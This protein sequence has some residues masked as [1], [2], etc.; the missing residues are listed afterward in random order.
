MYFSQPNQTNYVLKKY[1]YDI[2]VTFASNSFA[3]D[4]ITFNTE[5]D[6]VNYIPPLLIKGKLTNI[7]VGNNGNAGTIAN[8][9]GKLL[10]HY[11][12]NDQVAGQE[13]VYG[14]VVSGGYFAPYYSVAVST[15]DQ[16]NLKLV[17]YNQD[18]TLEFFSYIGSD[19]SSAANLGLF[20]YGNPTSDYASFTI[21]ANSGP[22]KFKWA[23]GSA[24]EFYNPFELSFGVDI[25]QVKETNTYNHFAVSRKNGVLRTFYNGI[26]ADTNTG[27]QAAANFNYEAQGNSIFNIGQAGGYQEVGGGNVRFSNFR[28]IIGQGYQEVNRPTSLPLGI[29]NGTGTRL[30]FIGEGATDSNR[31]PNSSSV[32]IGI[33]NSGSSDISYGNDAII[34]PR[35]LS[36]YE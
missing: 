18:F 34:N 19:V 15:S 2:A 7:S 9:K 31:A 1:G 22:I 27:I 33:S 21:G 4:G 35:A 26:L 17:P 5:A 16:E 6:P 10:F 30:L 20:G 3:G 8:S 11:V 23:T 28:Y 13:P 14:Q 29:V 25:A 12:S 32:N 24:A 36:P